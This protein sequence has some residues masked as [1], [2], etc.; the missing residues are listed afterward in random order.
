MAVPGP[1]MSDAEAASVGRANGGAQSS[2]IQAARQAQLIVAIGL[3]PP[4]R[5]CCSMP[6]SPLR[7]PGPGL[8]R[9][10]GGSNSGPAANA[11]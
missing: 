4:M 1:S 7:W 3:A 6:A 2:A 9:N 10:N 11:P 5:P 8:P